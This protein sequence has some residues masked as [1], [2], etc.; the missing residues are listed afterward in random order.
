MRKWLI[1]LLILLAVLVAVAAVWWL[2]VAGRVEMTTEQRTHL[3][4]EAERLVAHRDSIEQPDAAW[5]AARMSDDPDADELAQ[6]GQERLEWLAQQHAG[7][8]QT[9]YA[10]IWNIRDRMR[11]RLHGTNGNDKL[12]EAGDRAEVLRED[13]RF[14]IE[15]H[16]EKELSDQQARLFIAETDA[17]I[18]LVNEASA[19]EHIVWFPERT[20]RWLDETELP[21][22]YHAFRLLALRVGVLVELG[23]VN[24]AI[25]EFESLIEVYSRVDWNLSLIGVL[26][27]VISGDLLYREAAKALVEYSTLTPQQVTDWIDVVQKNKRDIVLSIAVDLFQ[28]AYLNVNDPILRFVNGLLFDTKGQ[29]EAEGV[30]VEDLFGATRRS[31][32]VCLDVAAYVSRE[33]AS[34]MTIEGQLACAEAFKRSPFLIYSNL[35]DDVEER[36]QWAGLEFIAARRQHGVLN[37]EV[38]E[39]VLTRWPALRAEWTETSMQLWVRTEFRFGQEPDSP[40]L[41]I[42]LEAN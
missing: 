32:A 37:E 41:E 26:C 40:L 39:G 33:R 14:K 34:L 31:E 15:L 5:V 18:A 11:S 25:D 22:G 8:L 30:S 28:T 35:I 29:W 9:E 12:F 20:E 24:Q 23:E 17:L 2:R 10:D 19:C 36:L 42:A 4:A 3:Q 21:S 6:L 27:H 7:L 38:A 16:G 13:V 1:P